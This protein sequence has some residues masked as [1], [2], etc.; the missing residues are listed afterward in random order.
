MGFDLGNAFKY[1]WR[2][3]LKPGTDRLED[4]RKARW[5]L[6]GYLET[7]AFHAHHCSQFA[8]YPPAAPI[9][10]DGPSAAPVRLAWE[11]V[12]AVSALSG[13]TKVMDHLVT[14]YLYADRDRVWR[15]R[16][17]LDALLAGAAP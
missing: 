17:A 12:L 8:Q 16:V 11:K 4:L 2:A 1:L 3:G 13:V 7:G 14:A 15:A 9:D 6:V 10:G 5:R